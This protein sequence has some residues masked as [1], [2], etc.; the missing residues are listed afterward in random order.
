MLILRRLT[1]SEKQDS[2]RIDMKRSIEL[3]FTDASKSFS[4]LKSREWN[5]TNLSV[6]AI[7]GV[8]ALI[9]G[10]TNECSQIAATVAMF[11]I[12]LVHFL[13]MLRC[14]SNLKVFRIRM[15]TLVLSH[16]CKECHSPTLFK[17]KERLKD[18]RKSK[19]DKE[20]EQETEFKEE[21]DFEEAVVD[22]GLLAGML[23]GSTWVTLAIALCVVWKPY[24]WQTL[25]TICG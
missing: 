9:R 19:Q 16:F 7:V 13:A 25:R 23:Y 2:T 15:R 6:L 12:S 3:L 21:T 24:S 17:I 20:A 1:V 11:L 10:S 5:I 14:E 4:D 8:L 18:K 22:E